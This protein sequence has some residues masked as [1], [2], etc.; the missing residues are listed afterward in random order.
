MVWFSLESVMPF[1]AFCSRIEINSEIKHSVGSIEEYTCPEG[2]KFATVFHVRSVWSALRAVANRKRM[3]SLWL[4][5]P[6]QEHNIT[7]CFHFF[8]SFDILIAQT[9]PWESLPSKFIYYSS[10]STFVS[11][12]MGLFFCYKLF[13][14][15]WSKE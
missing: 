14:L 10:R 6:N 8:L 11:L 4:F 15:L 12:E 5:D 1:I 13:F 2:V 9:L 3:P 7:F